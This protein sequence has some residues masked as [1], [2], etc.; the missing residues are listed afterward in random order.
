MPV[1]VLA[2]TTLCGATIFPITPPPEFAAV[3]MYGE[4]PSCC[5]VNFCKLPK[6]TFDEV[7]DPVDAIPS[8]PI[9]VPKKG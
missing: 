5:A 1:A 7:S 2:I 8:H 6:S 3:I 4:M 9:R